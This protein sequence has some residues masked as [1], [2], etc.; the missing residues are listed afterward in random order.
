M[1]EKIED[2]DVVSS[3][4]IPEFGDEDNL[5]GASQEETEGAVA[6]E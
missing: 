3:I 4:D 6:D 5:E 2:L 1:E